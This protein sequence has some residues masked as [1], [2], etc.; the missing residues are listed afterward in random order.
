VDVQRTKRGQ[1]PLAPAGPRPVGVNLGQA[2][3][4]HT[5]RAQFRTSTLWT[6]VA[7]VGIKASTTAGAV[8]LALTLSPADFGK[9]TAATSLALIFSVVFDAGFSVAAVRQLSCGA[10]SPAATR[11]SALTWRKRALLPVATLTVFSTVLSPHLGGWSLVPAVLLYMIATSFGSLGA[12][13]LTGL[14]RFRTSTLS[15][16]LGRGFGCL[17]LGLALA[18]GGP[19]SPAAA[20]L[21]LGAGELVTAATAFKL[22]ASASDMQSDTP[23][24]DQSTAIRAALPFAL[25]TFFTLVYNRADV[26]VVS[27]FAGTQVAGIYAPGSQLQNALMVL[28]GI[29]GAATI[30]IGARLLSQR[31]RAGTIWLVK[32]TLRLS[33]ALTIPACVALWIA[34]PRVLGATLGTSYAA[35]SGPA[36]LLL[37]SL[38]LLAVEIPL[39]GILTAASPRSSSVVYGLGLV[40][41]LTAHALL[42][43]RYGATGAAIAALSR[44]PVIL[45][46]ALVA[47]RRYVVRQR[48]PRTPAT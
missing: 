20:V 8:L 21:C 10:W 15:I 7:Q 4:R 1:G 30:P 28:P 22:F 44:E 41:C 17:A 33:L 26:Y 25:S 39:L 11:S 38:P 23:A 2:L 34:L 35:A 6:G 19:I 16:V 36:R 46:L 5:V 3:S 12:A 48:P 13:M 9:A 14:H 31:D 18:L 24:V 27:V 47:L 37:L 42:D 40:V 29:A 45:I 43:A 32:S